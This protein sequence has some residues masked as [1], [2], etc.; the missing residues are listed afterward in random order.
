MSSTNKLPT[1][2]FG[3]HHQPGEQSFVYVIIGSTAVF[4]AVVELAQA[5]GCSSCYLTLQMPK[6]IV[7]GKHT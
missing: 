4:N 1:N 2:K 3:C 5:V 7:W 6:T